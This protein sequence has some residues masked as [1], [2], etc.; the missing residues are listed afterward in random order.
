M[1]KKKVPKTLLS[2][3]TFGRANGLFKGSKT[4]HFIIKSYFYKSKV[5]KSKKSASNLRKKLDM[6]P[7]LRHNL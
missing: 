3:G 7:L 6:L 4:S 2:V 5:L 1:L